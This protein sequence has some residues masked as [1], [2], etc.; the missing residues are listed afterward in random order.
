MSNN[1]QDEPDE[2]E[3][4]FDGSKSNSDQG[5]VEGASE[6]GVSETVEPP[7]GFIDVE[8]ETSDDFIT[9]GTTDSGDQDID[10]GIFAPVRREKPEVKKSSS[11]MLAVSLLAF[12]G[13]GAFVYVSNPDIL[14]KVTN[15]LQGQESVTLSNESAVT[16][17]PEASHNDEVSQNAAPNPA[18]DVQPVDSNVAKSDIIVPHAQTDTQP[19]DSPSDLLGT[20]SPL[21][22]SNTKTVDP[23]VLEPAPL[24]ETPVVPAP[25][26]TSTAVPAVPPTMETEKLKSDQPAPVKVDAPAVHEVVT[27]LPDT[28]SAIVEKLPA[29][30][31]EPVAKLSTTITSVPPSSDVIV[32]TNDKEDEVVD[33]G[34]TKAPQVTATPMATPTATV[35]PKAEPVALEKKGNSSKENTLIPDDKKPVIVTSKEEQKVL[36]DANLNKYFDSPNGQMLKDIPAP[37]MDPKKG[38]NQSVIIVNKKAKKTAPQPSRPADKVAIETTSLTAQII[39]ANRA[40][41]LGRYDAAKEM[42]D[43]LYKLNPRDGQ[44]L[45][46]RALLLQKMGFADQAISAYEEL[47]DIYPDNTDAIVNLAGLIRKQYPA[48]ALNKLLDLHMKVPNNTAVTAQLGVAYADSGNYVD[49]LR[50]L[51]DAASM[52]PKNALH[53]YNMAVISE[54]AGKTSQAVSYYEKALELDAIY[55]DGKNN[56]PREKIYDRLA[57]IR[58]N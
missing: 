43:D 45:S 21:P 48:V 33:E 3:V 32:P 35:S 56:I 24:A 20:A 31:A 44:I 9:D 5:T 2:Y 37:S 16:D 30:T 53:F 34:N 17:T 51:G 6:A 28:A 42:Y 22:D 46:G 13:V 11:L 10:D 40:V 55:G 1:S 15:N 39:S 27:P 7:A 26:A 25:T 12:V 29:P 50:Y 58:G 41:K 38:G 36:D 23:A 18:P 54:K 14:S 19:S 8:S 57:Q 52:D 49:A 47:L 4:I